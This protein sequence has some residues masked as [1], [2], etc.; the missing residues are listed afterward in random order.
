MLT[1]HKNIHSMKRQ[2]NSPFILGW[3]F[4][5]KYRSVIYNIFVC[6]QNNSIQLILQSDAYTAEG[7]PFSESINTALCDF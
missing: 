7:T 6:L 4:N 1:A 3:Q 5:F 2:I